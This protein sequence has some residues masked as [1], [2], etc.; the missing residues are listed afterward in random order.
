MRIWRILL[1]LGLAGR[2][3]KKFASKQ[4]AA[5]KGSFM[6]SEIIYS[7]I[8]ADTTAIGLV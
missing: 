1:V 2:T 5:S 7:R 6:L 8:I 4:Y 3:L